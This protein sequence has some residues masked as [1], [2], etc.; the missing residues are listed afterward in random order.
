MD[1]AHWGSTMDLSRAKNIG[2]KRSFIVLGL[3]VGLVFTGRMALKTAREVQHQNLMHEGIQTCF[4]RVHQTFT[5][6]MLGSG[7]GE[8]LTK[9]FLET[10]SRCFSEVVQLADAQFTKTINE[11]PRITNTLA[12]E[13]HLFQERINSNASAFTQ[14][15]D[16][17]LFLNQLATRFENLERLRNDSLQM[18]D[19]RGHKLND[20]LSTIRGAFFVIAFCLVVFL[21]F[22]FFILRKEAALTADI[23]REAQ[24]ILE[25]NEMSTLRVQEV[26]RRAL[27][28]K[29]YVYC[30]SLFTQYQQYQNLTDKEVGYRR[31][32]EVQFAPSND[33][34]LEQKIEQLWEAADRPEKDLVVYEE[35]FH[36]KMNFDV[37]SVE[38]EEAIITRS[39]AELS[40]I[41][42][43][44][45]EV[46]APQFQVQGIELEMNLD[47]RVRLA[48]DEESVSLLIFQAI[49][50]IIPEGSTNSRHLISVDTVS[51][52]NVA[53]CTIEVDLGSF[54]HSLIQSQLGLLRLDS[55]YIPLEI[56]QCLDS[57][58]L[59]DAKFSFDN[60][61]DDQGKA[62]GKM[63]KLTFRQGE[64]LK[65]QGV[66]LQT[67]KKGT[68]REILQALSQ[69]N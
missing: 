3:V 69:D 59:I 5:A 22:E 32:E 12:G 30:E 61:Y 51:L 62:C 10:T 63:V 54:D 57:A 40:S 9:S 68:K 65:S 33:T 31:S 35:S 6:R 21:V 19:Q 67:V 53:V 13:V 20:I 14:G 36:S 52:G 7:A 49:N 2:I 66:R 45:A 18:L 29:N 47:D 16:Q 8:Y 27:E 43:N 11:L 38:Q 48:A 24:D 23:E 42:E 64:E 44:L 39:G 1:R 26:I 37:N 60:L 46:L 56:R 41:I 4:T 28:H 15:Q 50:A 55:Q 34:K 58:P 25:K 17:R